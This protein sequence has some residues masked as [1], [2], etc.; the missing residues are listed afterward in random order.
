VVMNCCFYLVIDCILFGTVVVAEF[1]FVI[2]LVAIVVCSLRN[3][4][5]LVLVVVGVYVL[6]DIRLFYD[7]I[8]L[9]FTALNAVLFA[10]YVVFGH[11]MSQGLRWIDGLV[12]VMGV[13]IVFALPINLRT[14]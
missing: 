12:L 6:T 7:W 11:R 14:T 10:A 5:A 1:A 9:V 13:A 3:L 8:G 4:L 2:V